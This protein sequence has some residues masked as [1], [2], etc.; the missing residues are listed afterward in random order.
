MGDGWWV[1]YDGRKQKEEL[2]VAVGSLF[3]GRAHTGERPY[4]VYIGRTRGNAP[5]L[6][7]SGAHGGTPL[8]LTPNS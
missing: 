7:T 2:T 8:Q 5:T 1:M 3:V 4:I 6:F